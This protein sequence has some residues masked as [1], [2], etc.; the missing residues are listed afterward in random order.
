[1][2]FTQTILVPRTGGDNWCVHWRCASVP[3]TRP[4]SKTLSPMTIST[5][6]Q[7]WNRAIF[8]A[9]YWTFGHDCV[10]P[11][12]SDRFTQCR[13]TV[14]LTRGDLSAYLTESY[15]FHIWWLVSPTLPLCTWNRQL[16]VDIAPAGTPVRPW[17][18]WTLIHSSVWHR[19][20]PEGI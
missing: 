5:A 3:H 8:Y 10:D 2:Y 16:Y 12:A 19:I 15:H 7:V 4:K 20:L 17:E 1:M 14:L 13:D 6:K 18:W 11:A 9:R